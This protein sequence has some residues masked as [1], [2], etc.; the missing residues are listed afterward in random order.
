MARLAASEHFRF[1][2]IDLCA[3]GGLSDLLAEHADTTHIVHLAAQAGVGHSLVDPCAYIASNIMGHVV[4]LEAARHLKHLRHIVYASSSSV[5]GL[6]TSMPF[7]ESDPVDRPGSFYAVT[8][9]SGELTAHAYA[10]LY[11]LPQTGLRLFTA[12]GPWGRPDMAYYKFAEAIDKGQPLTLYRGKGLARD[13]TYI[14]DIVLGILA[15]LD[16]PPQEG[17]SRLLN[18]GGGAP[19]AVERLVLLLEKELG[20]SAIIDERSRPLSDVEATW[21]SHDEITALTGWQPV[22]SLEEGVKNFVRWYQGYTTAS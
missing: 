4:L 13:F 7:C 22:V 18:L 10:H 15:T 8:K 5:Y 11:G 2:P 3:P 19:T 21:S 1:Y 17:E 9:R 6:N 20:R 16:L 12:Y 14:D